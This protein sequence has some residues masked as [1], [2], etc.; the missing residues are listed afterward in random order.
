MR[1][2]CLQSVP[3]R[4][5]PFVDLAEKLGAMTGQLLESPVK[6]VEFCYMGDVAKLNTKPM[7]AAALAGLLKPM[8]SEVNMVSAPAIASDRGLEVKESTCDDAS[9]VD[10][11]I[12]LIIKTEER[13]LVVSG[14]LYAG[15]PRLLNLFGVS[16]DAAF[17]PN[18]LYVRNED[19]PGFIGALGS[20]LGESNVNIA[21]FSL[22]R[23]QQGGSAICLVSVDEPVSA[24]IQAKV[25]EIKQV[26]YVSAL[27]F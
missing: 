15:E 26:K 5:K 12:K 7:T 16:M 17:A 20:L 2:I 1:L 25:R 18:M 24:D 3:K 21:T 14:S 11:L 27:S 10:N 8:M 13:E 6:S 4:L 19:K 22:G 23:T 9:D